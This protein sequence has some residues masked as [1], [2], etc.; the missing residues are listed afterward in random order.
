M[1]TWNDVAIYNAQK[2]WEHA[3]RE[4]VFREVICSIKGCSVDLLSFNEVKDSLHLTEM[5][6]HG[7]HEIDLKHIRGSVGRYQD[8][9]TD[10][11]PRKKHLRERWESVDRYISNQGESPIQVYQVGK[12][13]FVIDGNHRVSVARQ[14]GRNSI[15]AEVWQYVTPVE[16]SSEADHNELLLKAEHANFL[17]KTQIAKHKPDH[18]IAI[19]TPGGYRSLIAQL[20]TYRSGLDG[21]QGE[22]VSM[23]EASLKW[24]D[25][26]YAPATRTIRESGVLDRYPKRTEADL[27]IW[28]W[29]NQENLKD[30]SPYDLQ[31]AFKGNRIP[32]DEA[33]I[34]RLKRSIDDLSAKLSSKNN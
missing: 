29:A 1:E 4:A 33:L 25:E 11:L 16:L 6:Y 15:P 3:R 18:N 27:F 31:E 20:E 22:S 2:D 34:S 23:E 19:T 24:Y 7:I 30:F 5:S 8:F 9:D 28:L 14:L 12:A 21:A 17:A 32:G 13:Y 26:V 10:F